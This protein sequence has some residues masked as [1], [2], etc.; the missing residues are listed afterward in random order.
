MIVTVSIIL[1]QSQVDAGSLIQ[2]E[3][4]E[5]APRRILEKIMCARPTLDWS[6]S[7]NISCYLLFFHVS[8]FFLLFFVSLTYEL[9]H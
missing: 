7:N 1:V 2:V 6:R 4:N 8:H 5:R 9:P 3:R